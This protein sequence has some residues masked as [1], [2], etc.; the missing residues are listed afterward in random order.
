MNAKLLLPTLAL[1]LGACGD[2]KNPN[3]M[4]DEQTSRAQPKVISA[5]P[6][7]PDSAAA[8]T[9]N[10][11]M[12]ADTSLT[13]AW[14]ILDG[15][16]R[17]HDAAVL[18]Q[19]IDREFG[20]W[21]VENAGGKPLVTRVA[22]SENFRDARRQ[23]LFN[24]D[25]TLMT[26]AAPKV[27]AALPVAACPAGTFATAGCFDGPATRFRAA[28]FWQRATIKGGNRNQGTAAQGRA[29]RSVLQT[30]TGYQFHFSKT[31]GAGGRW[32]L[33]FM[34]LRGPCQ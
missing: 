28:G 11:V 34:D 18:N 7:K 32:K 3:G 2:V 33:V 6:P 4:P 5:R 22:Q 23:P 25:K 27:V 21:I 19:L 13:G 1:L 10:P 14:L 17:G 15:A 20:L 24:L 30:S 31:A 29:V 8:I 26:C 12:P 16:L 9:E